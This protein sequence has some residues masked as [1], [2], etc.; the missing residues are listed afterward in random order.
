[1]KAN[2][3]NCRQIDTNDITNRVKTFEDAV[4]ALGSDNQLV[5]DYYAIADKTCAMDIIAFAK[6]R[7]IAEALN[8]GWRP[9]FDGKE[10]RY[11]PW[12]YLYTKEEYDNLNKKKKNECRVVGR[13]DKSTYAVVG[14]AF[15]SEY[16]ASTYLYSHYNSLLAFKTRELALYFAMQFTD[17]LYDFLFA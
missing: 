16:M 11:Y 10:S 8:E 2:E 14:L 1:M 15:A 13:S 3:K 12:F 17:I 7:V 4:A 6:L 9:K 5:I